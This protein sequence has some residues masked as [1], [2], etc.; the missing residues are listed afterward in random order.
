MKVYCVNADT[1]VP[2]MA[3]GGGAALLSGPRPAG[4]LQISA[5]DAQNQ[6]FESAIT[7][8]IYSKM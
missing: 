2:V 7:A 8:R 1:T 4:R 6:S 5:C 3:A